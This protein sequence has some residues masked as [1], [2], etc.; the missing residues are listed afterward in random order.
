MSAVPASRPR[1][2]ADLTAITCRSLAG[3]V[4]GRPSADTACSSL[5]RSSPRT[6]TARSVPAAT[7]AAT[8]RELSTAGPM[9][10]MTADLIA[11]VEDSSA[12]GG[13]GAS[14]ACVRSACSKKRR[15]PE[16]GSLAHQRGRGDFG[17]RDAAAAARP[18]VRRAGPP[19]SARPARPSRPAA[20]RA[21][22]DPPRSRGR[23]APAST[24]SATSAEL[25]AVRRPR[26]P[27]CRAR[28]AVSQP[29]SRYSA[30]VMLA[31]T[32]S[33]ASLRRATP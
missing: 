16:A 19:R 14:P 20:H 30:T 23:R 12:T 2:W 29:G 33:P 5:V 10:A 11:V 8:A 17:G 27:A 1:R 13:T 9:P 4:S 22:R 7:S 6:G 21:G 32:R 3:P 24:A 18:R 26:S 31:A 25:P 28:S 15:V